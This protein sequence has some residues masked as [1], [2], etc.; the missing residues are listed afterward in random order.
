MRAV[1]M[2]LEAALLVMQNGG[3][4]VAADR[5][6]SNVLKGHEGEAATAVWRLDFVAVRTAAE[7]ESS[8]VVR[9]VGTTGVN[10]S[11]ASDAILAERLA[12]RKITAADFGAEPSKGT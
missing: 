12:Q 2:A 7:G 11:R 10:L 4:T 8:T 5:T 3:S 1:D 9:P 6:F